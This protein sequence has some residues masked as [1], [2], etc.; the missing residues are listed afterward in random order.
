MLSSDPRVTR[1]ALRLEP[2]GR[3][4]IVGAVTIGTT[5][6]TPIRVHAKTAVRDESQIAPTDPVAVVAVDARV[7]RFVVHRIADKLFVA[8]HTGH[9]G[10]N[11]LGEYLLVD[12]D[13]DHATGTATRQIGIRVACQTVFV[14]LGREP[15]R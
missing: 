5:R 1:L 6:R 10:M 2:S 9:V 4:Y 15:T 12:K 3:F 11:R 14:L 8:V 13:R 7:D